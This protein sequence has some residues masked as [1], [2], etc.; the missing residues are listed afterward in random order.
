MYEQALSLGLHLVGF[1]E[2]S[3]R[4]EGFTYTHE[5]R[6]SLTRNLPRYVQEVLALR[7][8]PRRGSGGE[9]C[10]VAFGMEMDWLSGEEE[11]AKQAA[12]A[13]PFDYRIGSVHFID[14]WGFDDGIGPWKD[15]SQEE[16]EQWYTA[17]FTA[18]QAMLA[19]GLYQIA[20][21][22]DLIKI[23]S[24]DQFHIWLDSDSART[25]LG[26]ALDTLKAQGMVMEVSS[27][28]LRKKCREI[29]PCPAIMHMARVRDIPIS[30]A[31]D[32][33]ERGDIAYA[34]DALA[35]YAATFGYTEHAFFSDGRMTSVPFAL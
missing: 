8:A 22:P 16:C 10:R 24:V 1:T 11:F 29:Y 5:Y 19:S 25:L 2:H 30:F 13:Y 35:A 32:A 34:F 9:L 27:A 31:S 7:D 18:W 6:E 17:Y 4:P 33:H 20:A 28:G 26:R 21:H 3:P 14:H 12:H 15:A 23:F